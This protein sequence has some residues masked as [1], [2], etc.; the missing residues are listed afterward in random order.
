MAQCDAF[1]DAL[2]EERRVNS[3][4][5]HVRAPPRDIS[6][7]KLTGSGE[8]DLLN[9]IAVLGRPRCQL[10]PQEVIEYVGKNYLHSFA[11][12]HTPEVLRDACEVLVSRRWLSKE[13]N[14]YRATKDENSDRQ[15]AQL[16]MGKL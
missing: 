2:T 15:E 5:T 4:P 11:S 7:A 8:E 16:T 13:G 14:Y 1:V 12:L 6:L 10:V 3:T 9:L